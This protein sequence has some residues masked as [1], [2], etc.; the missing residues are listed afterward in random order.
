LKRDNSDFRFRGQDKRADV[1]QGLKRTFSKK[2]LLRL[3]M[4]IICDFG[5][6]KQRT[7]LGIK[8]N[9]EHPA[10]NLTTTRDAPPRP[11]P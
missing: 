2:V 5:T 11:A 9:E 1:Y 7:A 10:A 8:E 4:D 3:A 6:R